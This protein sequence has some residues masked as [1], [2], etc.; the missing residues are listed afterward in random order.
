MRSMQAARISCDSVVAAAAAAAAAV[1]GN[2]I[3][4]AQDGSIHSS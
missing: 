1:V 2:D 3:Q 4:H